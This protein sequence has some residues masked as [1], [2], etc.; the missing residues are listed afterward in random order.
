MKLKTLQNEI[1]EIYYQMVMGGSG[2]DK[3]LRDEQAKE[4]KNEQV[5]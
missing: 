1:D 4:K 5:S 2:Y 3:K